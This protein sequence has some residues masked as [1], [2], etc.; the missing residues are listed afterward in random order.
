MW[1]IEQDRS[2]GNIPVICCL[3]SLVCLRSVGLVPSG[4]RAAVEYFEEMMPRNSQMNPLQRFVG[5][6]VESGRQA[7][8]C[9]SK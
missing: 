6:R 9:A 3:I 1:W 5:D 7:R 2:P 8:R 4:Y